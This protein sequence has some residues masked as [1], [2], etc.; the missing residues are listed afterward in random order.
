MP[1]GH[2]KFYCDLTFGLLKKK[3]KNTQVSD[4]NQLERCVL[5]SSPRSELN[6]CH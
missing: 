1:V 3:F 4:L 6:K 5:N 2:T